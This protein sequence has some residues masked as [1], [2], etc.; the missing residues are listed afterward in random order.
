MKDVES[1]ED[2]LAVILEREIFGQALSP[3][4]APIAAKEFK[5]LVERMVAASQRD[6]AKYP[7]ELVITEVAERVVKK[8]LVRLGVS[9]AILT[10]GTVNSWWSLGATVLIGIVVDQV[11]EWIDAP[12]EGME[13]EVSAA[14]DSLSQDAS[15]IIEEE[16]HKTLS[17]R[18]EFW[19]RA[20]AK[21]LSNWY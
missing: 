11:W 2:E 19:D 7:A 9:G 3:D 1:I 17:Q 13:R 21:L 12:V 6:V 20:A 8:V 5:E 14:L 10:A 15:M 16:M 18:R 4:G